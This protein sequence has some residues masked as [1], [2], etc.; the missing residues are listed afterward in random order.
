[1]HGYAIPAYHASINIINIIEPISTVF[2]IVSDTSDVKAGIACLTFILTS[3]VKNNVI[4]EVLSNELQQ[5][6]LPKGMLCL[7]FSN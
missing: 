5:L 4:S 7:A 3:G 2:V 6:G 1:M